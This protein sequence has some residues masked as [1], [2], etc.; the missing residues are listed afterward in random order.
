MAN[1]KERLRRFRDIT[2]V[3]SYSQTVDVTYMKKLCFQGIPDEQGI[4]P[5]CWKL[6]LGYLPPDKTQWGS[7]LTENRVCYYNFVKDLIVNPGEEDSVSPTG[8]DHPLNNAPDS[9][10]NTYFKDNVILEQIDK[11]VRRTLPDFAF[12][13]QPVETSHFSPLSPHPLESQPVPSKETSRLFE[14]IKGR[15]ALFKRLQ[16]INKNFGARSR[17]ISKR[18]PKPTRKISLNIAVSPSSEGVVDPATPSEKVGDDETCDLHWEA[19]ERLLFIYAKLN[20]G[21]GYVQGMN[22]ILGPIYYT[23]ANDPD[24]ET[25]AHAEADSFFVFTLLMS[26]IRDHFVKSL[27]HNTDS[28]IN[29][30][31]KRMNELLKEMDYELWQN[32]EDKNILPTYYA[33]RWLTVM[34]TQEFS[35]PEVIRLWD[36]I[37]ADQDRGNGFGFLDTFCCA[38]VI[39]IRTEILSTSFVNTVKLLQNY[40]I[41][42]IHVVLQKAYELRKLQQPRPAGPVTQQAPGDPEK[43]ESDLA[44]GYPSIPISPTCSDVGINEKTADELHYKAPKLTEYPTDESDDD[45]EFTSNNAANNAT[46]SVTT[47]LVGGYASKERTNDFEEVDLRSDIDT[48][49]PSSNHVSENKGLQFLKS[50]V[51]IFSKLNTNHD[52]LVSAG[53]V[54]SKLG[55]GGRRFA[56]F[57]KERKAN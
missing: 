17:N 31:M 39:C 43:V 38:M 51:N 8:S 14:P 22:E 21:V 12:F 2:N 54:A 37:L 27:D 20:P 5:T 30:S 41:S 23:M 53:S 32:L 10:W 24:E 47:Q 34:C 35:L 40:P 33:F 46:A 19:I 11:D 36:S 55:Q 28:G 1:Y 29:A 4:R 52:A 3:H 6:L 16:T 45:G 56:A 13:Q 15:R 50:K 49:Y 57:W 44:D 42:D 25:R 26:N 7:I 9:K 48:Q 18:S